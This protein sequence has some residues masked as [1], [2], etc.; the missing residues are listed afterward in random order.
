MSAVSNTCS[1]CGGNISQG[2]TLTTSL[3]VG[4][5]CFTAAAW[6]ETEYKWSNDL[7][8]LY[9]SVTEKLFPTSSLGKISKMTFQQSRDV[10]EFLLFWAVSVSVQSYFRINIQL[11]IWEETLYGV[12]KQILLLSL[13]RGSSAVRSPLTTKVQI[14]HAAACVCRTDVSVLTVSDHFTLNETIESFFLCPSDVQQIKCLSA[15]N[16]RHEGLLWTK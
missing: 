16:Q 10:V 8:L 9:P 2:I 11:Y 7:T 1:W 12:F 15:A 4:V 5:T 13:M 6:M 3:P 14:M